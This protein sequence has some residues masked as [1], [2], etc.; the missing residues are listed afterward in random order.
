MVA[1]ALLIAML[2]LLEYVYYP[3]IFSHSQ[4]HCYSASD[5]QALLSASLF[6][7]SKYNNPNKE[8][9]SRLV[10]LNT[11]CS[12]SHYRPPLLYNMLKTFGSRHNQQEVVL[13]FKDSMQLVIDFQFFSKAKASV[14]TMKTFFYLRFRDSTVLL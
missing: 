14:E 10:I 11:Y 9:A 6:A 3:T 1:I 13:E 4:N 5:M 2:Y 8:Q 12:R 7:I